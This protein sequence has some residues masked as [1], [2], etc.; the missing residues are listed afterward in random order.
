MSMKFR[1]VFNKK[2]ISTYTDAHTF[3]AYYVSI[4]FT[5]FSQSA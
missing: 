1:G 4:H 3:Y 5:E 2:W